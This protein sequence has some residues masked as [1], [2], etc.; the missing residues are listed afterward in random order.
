MSF[1]GYMQIVF[2][3]IVPAIIAIIVEII[4]SNQNVKKKYISVT[5]RIWVIIFVI[6][7]L[8]YYLTKQ[9]KPEVVDDEF[10]MKNEIIETGNQSPVAMDGGVVNVTY[11]NNDSSNTSLESVKSN[12]IN[13]DKT[14]TVDS[15][16]NNGTLIIYSDKVID[17]PPNPVKHDIQISFLIESSSYP[18]EE[19]GIY[20]NDKEKELLY[21]AKELCENKKYDEAITIYKCDGLKDNPYAQVNIGYLYAHGYGYDENVET[22][23]KI[24]DSID[25]D[26]AKRNKLA[27]LITSNMDGKNDAE[28]KN[29]IDYF[30]NK[31]D[32]Y[33]QNYITNC[34]YG[35]NVES[36]SDRE[37]NILCNLKDLYVLE[38]GVPINST[39]THYLNNAYK[40]LTYIGLSHHWNENHTMSAYYHYNVFQCR[41]LDWLEKIYA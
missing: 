20:N 19:I 9:E 5:I 4:F 25:M 11:N 37:K 33:V 39:Q 21:K 13:E 12:S 31:D 24:Y 41:Y 32:Y 29:L 2:C 3:T 16:W 35:K 36:L 22:A 38:I 18:E 23:L 10:T 28:I 15:T 34:I 26:I 30:I 40:K 6:V 17:A 27:L 14:Q 1:D 8:I 7:T